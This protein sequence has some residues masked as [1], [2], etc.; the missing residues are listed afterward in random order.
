MDPFL[1]HLLRSQDLIDTFQYWSVMEKIWAEVFDVILLR[2][3]SD[4]SP[5]VSKPDVNW[6]M[7]HMPSQT[8]ATSVVIWLTRLILFSKHVNKSDFV[9]L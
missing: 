2:T 3:E 4:S 7:I 1:P 8:L 9:D 6:M 5:N